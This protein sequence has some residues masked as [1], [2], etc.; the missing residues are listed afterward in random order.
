MQADR[1]DPGSENS[2]YTQ[3]L[4]VVPRGRILRVLS[5]GS[6]ICRLGAVRRQLSVLDRTQRRLWAHGGRPCEAGV[7][8]A[9]PTKCLMHA[10]AAC[11][12]HNCLL[13]PVTDSSY[14][15][16]SVSPGWRSLFDIVNRIRNRARA[17]PRHRGIG[18]P[19]G[20][21]QNA[22]GLNFEFSCS[23]LPQDDIPPRRLAPLYPL[24]ID[25]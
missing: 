10:A 12:P 16:L 7:V 1:R 20:L 25:P 17:G 23:T 8:S 14:K 6:P 24:G 9:R 11:R 4:L 2:A 22:I 13:T 3:G 19:E 5:G 21:T 15:V 18:G